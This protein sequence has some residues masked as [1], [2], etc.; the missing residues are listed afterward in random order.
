MNPSTIKA[1]KRFSKQLLAFSSPLDG[2]WTMSDEQFSKDRA[3]YIEVFGLTQPDAEEMDAIVAA[4]LEIANHELDRQGV[5]D[6][7]KI[8]IP[9]A[10]RF[11]DNSD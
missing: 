5:R 10:E 9:L 7:A 4:I 2:D 8:V 3:Y 6:I 11:I 1:A